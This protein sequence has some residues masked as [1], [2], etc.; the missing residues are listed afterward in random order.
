MLL[1]SHNYGHPWGW[2]IL[3]RIHNSHLDSING[4]LITLG[5]IYNFYIITTSWKG[6]KTSP[7][8]ILVCPFSYFSPSCPLK[9]YT[10]DNISENKLIN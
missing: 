6:Q 9:F 8:S 4:L 1:S 3:G 7:F 2:N 5:V 10:S